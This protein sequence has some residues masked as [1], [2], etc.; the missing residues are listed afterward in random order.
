MVGS[1]AAAMLKG[2]VSTNIVKTLDY[3][4]HHI[5]AACIV[6]DT[7]GRRRERHE[8]LPLFC[9]S[10]TAGLLGSHFLQE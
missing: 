9:P 3:H 4:M 7:K 6:T 2:L 8:A 10:D 5:C 1:S